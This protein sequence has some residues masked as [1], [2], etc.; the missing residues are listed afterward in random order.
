[1][2]Q[3]PTPVAAAKARGES[4][5][6]AAIRAI[7][8]GSLKERKA[9]N[10]KQEHAL[11]QQ[12]LA[13]SAQPVQTDIS[14]FLALADAWSQKPSNLAGHYK[15]PE[16][17]DERT[18]KLSG[19]E[20]KLAGR[21]K[22]ISDTETE[23]LK[24]QLQEELGLGRNAALREA[25][26]T[27]SEQVKDP[28]EAQSKAAMFGKMMEKAN[29]DL[30]KANSQFDRTSLKGSLQSS[31]LYPEMIRPQP[32]KEARNAEL[33]FSNAIA[34]FQSGATIKPEEFVVFES[35]YFPRAGDGP[36]L[37]AKKKAN[38]EQ[39]IALMRAGAGPEAWSRA[40]LPYSTADAGNIA[41]AGPLKSAFTGN[42]AVAKPAAITNTPVGTIVNGYKKLYEGDD[43]NLA[44]WGKQ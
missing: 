2:N 16:S 20:D 24:L 7:Q 41:K 42:T 14:P 25:A 9:A 19:L 27:K 1:M 36:E 32:V 38:R 18:V 5:L 37:L 29:L 15:R 28:K 40:G 6:S 31:S 11:L 39:A 26:Q 10:K 43:E 23:L 22:G 21:Q 8:E 33:N 12:M 17:T 13:T 34:R 30:D 3:D 35:M 4:A 44:L